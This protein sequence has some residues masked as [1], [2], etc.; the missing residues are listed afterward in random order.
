M[1]EGGTKILN[2]KTPLLI[3]AWDY[4]IVRAASV[5]KQS[6]KR[7]LSW[8]EHP[9]HLQVSRTQV[10]NRLSDFRSVA[11]ELLLSSPC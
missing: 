7:R 5:G 3:G 4:S 1:P 8:W 9:V 6:C 10:R 2:F 11:E